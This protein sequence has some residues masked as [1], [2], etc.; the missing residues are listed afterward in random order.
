M[1]QF[2]VY[3]HCK[4][5][6]AVTVLEWHRWTVGLCVLMLTLHRPL[7]CSQPLQRKMNLG[8]RNYNEKRQICALHVLILIQVS[9]EEVY[10]FTFINPYD[11]SHISAHLAAIWPLLLVVETLP[12]P[13]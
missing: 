3:T 8:G 9:M 10:F 4:P 1:V 6:H 13:S 7:H 2:C 11:C 5:R 12:P